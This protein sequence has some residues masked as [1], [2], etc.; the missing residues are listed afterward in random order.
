MAKMGKEAKSDNTELIGDQ[1]K[2]AFQDTVDEGVPDRFRKLID[3]NLK[4]AYDET[5]QEGVPDR[6]AQL[7]AELKSAANK[8]SHR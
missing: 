4:H 1:L 5:V 3:R 8:G 2:A 6:F 7:I